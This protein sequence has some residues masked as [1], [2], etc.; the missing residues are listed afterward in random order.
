M[1]AGETEREGGEH[2]LL[3]SFWL[4]NFAEVVDGFES[5]LFN[6]IYKYNHKIDYSVPPSRFINLFLKIQVQRCCTTFYSR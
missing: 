3:L 6:E 5:S 4:A 1:Q 2:L